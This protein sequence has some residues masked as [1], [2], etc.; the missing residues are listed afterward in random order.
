MPD[1]KFYSDYVD[2]LINVLDAVEKDL[3]NHIIEGEPKLSTL[4]NRI[5]D[6]NNFAGAFLAKELGE[7]GVDLETALDT[8]NK[9]K[10]RRLRDG[11]YRLRRHFAD[12]EDLTADDVEGW[13]HH[14]M[15]QSAGTGS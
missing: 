14:Y 8:L 2:R 3:S 7:A 10:I 15:S 12:L 4:A 5:N 1:I 11:L 13:Y 9:Q 6:G